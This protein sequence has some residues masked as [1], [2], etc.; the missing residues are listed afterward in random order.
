MAVTT[1]ELNRRFDYHP[2]TDPAVREAHEK[3]RALVKQ[4]A[5]DLLELCPEAAGRESA[6]TLTALEEAMFWT[7]AAIARHSPRA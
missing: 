6:L 3:A 5:V 1:E 4:V 2:P 7:N